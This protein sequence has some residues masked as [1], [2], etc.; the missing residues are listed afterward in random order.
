MRV[1]LYGRVSSELQSQASI[2]DQ[3]RVCEERASKEGWVIIER[4]SDQSISGATMMRPGLQELLKDANKGKFDIV[5][6]EALDR[7]ARD[8]EFVAAI[9]KRL[10]FENIKLVTLSEGLISELHVGLSGLMGALYIKQLAEKTIRGQRGRAEAGK[11]AA[12]KAYGYDVVRSLDSNGKPVRGERV[13]NPEQAPIVR[14]IFRDY[15]NGK[16]SYKIARELNAEG[17]PGPRGPW[18]DGTLRG[19]KKRGLGILN[20]EIY[21]GLMIY[22]KVRYPK[23]PMTQ[24]RTRVSRINS[25]DDLVRTEVPDLRIVDQE[26]WDRVKAKQAEIERKP[27]LGQ[28]KRPPKLFSYLLQ[29]GECGGGM[30]MSSRTAYACNA[31][32]KKGTCSNRLS[33]DRVVLEK[34]V[35]SALRSRLMHPALCE[36]FCRAYVARINQNRMEQ[37]AAAEAHGAELA[38]VERQLTKLVDALK[39]GIDP[40]LLREEINDLSSRKNDLIAKLEQ[41]V[42]APTLIHPRMADRYHVEVQRLLEALNEPE[43]YEE[44]ADLVRKLVSKIVLRPNEDRSKLI[45]DLH[46]DLAGILLIAAEHTSARSAKPQGGRVSYAFEIEQAREV[47]VSTASAHE[48]LVDGAEKALHLGDHRSLQDVVVEGTGFEPVYA[49]AGRFTVCCL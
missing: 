23:N 26:L 31:S 19:N 33:K 37:N 35:I 13:I 4:Y 14:R 15:A 45:I 22:G 30:S 9:Y 34:A 44:S 36:A 41:R 47:I 29:C 21:M 7:M 5:L 32:R 17:V 40:T 42:E 2:P 24:G 46:G 8:Q 12:G 18:S 43:R 48:P 3:F 6:T 10:S 39:S 25:A 11:C 38:R 16:S 28:K 20:N 49:H 27:S 1:A